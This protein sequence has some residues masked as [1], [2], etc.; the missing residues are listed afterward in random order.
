MAGGRKKEFDK[1]DALVEAMKVFWKK[2]YLGASLTDLIQAMGINKPS[3]YATFGNKEQLFL[4]VTDYYLTQI[5]TP[6]DS[7]LLDETLTQKQILKSYIMAKIENQCRDDTPRG[8]FISYCATE[9]KGD[10]LPE[11]AKLCIENAGKEAYTVLLT[12]FQ[13]QESQ[14]NKAQQTN[15]ISPEDKTMA[16]FTLLQG[17]A[18]MA[19][20]NA[21][22]D[23]F[24]SMVDM[25]LKGMDLD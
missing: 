18:T 9:G 25:L 12:F 3:L 7:F 5:A 8:C 1:Q 13:K 22:P 21:N 4:Q 14:A 2:G 11:I 6:P 15:S 16:V 23:D 17:T 20:L 19:R 24:E 10:N